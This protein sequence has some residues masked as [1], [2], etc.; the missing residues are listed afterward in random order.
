MMKAFI[1]FSLLSCFM[2]LA[3]NSEAQTE[4]SPLDTIKVS[5]E[6]KNGSLLDLFKQI[7]AQTQ[8]TFAYREDII[9]SPIGINIAKDTLTVKDALDI[10]LARTTLTYRLQDYSIVISKKNESPVNP[11]IISGSVKDKTGAPIPG[12]SIMIR[13]SSQGT[14]T[15]ENGNFN[16][17]VLSNEYIVFSFVG[18]KTFTTSPG[19]LTVIDVILEEDVSLLR[20]VVVSAGYYDVKKTESTGNISRVTAKDLEKQPVNNPLAALQGRMPGVFIQQT[21][22]TPGGEF[23]IQIR[24][25]NSLRVDGND[26]LY[27]IDGVILST[28]K[29]FSYYANSGGVF[30]GPGGASSGSGVSPLTLLNMADIESIEIL[31]DADATAIYGSRGANGVVLITTKKGKPGK[32]TFDLNVY[33]GV[34]TVKPIDYLNT[35]E[36]LALRRQAFANDGLIP[37]AN[38][39]DDGSAAN[40]FRLFAPDLMVWDTTRYTNW[41]KK[42]IKQAATTSVQASLSGGSELTKFLFSVGYRRENS[43]YPG[44]LA[45]QK[46]SFH[47][48]T[49][50]S[51][52][53]KKLNVDVSITG[54][55][56]RNDQPGLALMEQINLPPN[57]PELLNDDG[58]LNWNDWEYSSTG[59]NPLYGS[60]ITYYSNAVNFNGNTAIGYEILEGLRLKSS[61]GI[62]YLHSDERNIKPSTYYNPNLN[63]TSEQ[64][65]VTDAFGTN[66]SWLIEPQLTWDKQAGKAKVNI[67]IGTTFQE[68]QLARQADLYIGFPSDALANNLAAATTKYNWEYVRTLYRYS[69]LFGRVNF[70]W[71]GK[72]ILNLTARRDGSSRFGPRKQFANF[73]AIG[74]AWLFSNESFI[75]DNISFLSFGKLRGSY[76]STGNDQIGDYQYLDSYVP[77]SLGA[78]QY[79]GVAILSPAQLFNADYAWETNKKFEA[80]IELGFI[81]DR[82]NLSVS[83][84]LNRSSNQLVNYTLPQTTGFGGILANLPAVVQNTGIEIELSTV[85]IKTEH[86]NWSTSVNVTVPR[87]KLISF[88]DL[89]SS[90]YANQYVVGKPLSITSVFTSTG[91]DPQSGLWTFKDADGDGFVT[92]ENDRTKFVYTGYDYFGGFSNTFSY[93]GLTLDV[94]FQFVKQTGT[95]A[96][97]GYPGG[98]FNVPTSA[99][100][101]D[102]WTEEGD[103][104]TRQ[105]FFVNDPDAQDAFGKYRNSDAARKDASFIRLKN[106][107]VSYTVP[108]KWTKAVGCRVYV[109]G[110]NLLLITKYKGGDPETQYYGVLPPLRMLTAG[111][112]FT[113]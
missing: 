14:V 27:V 112:Q 49:T 61:F 105:R 11:V 103:Q 29:T 69:A 80:A 38:P 67:L 101:G 87:N 77:G 83:Y 50:H 17:A 108:K 84:F 40:G 23:R 66:Q 98:F 111:V 72:Y 30:S 89:E 42:F 81:E 15:D 36:Y 63:Y 56:D 53:N 1:W 106:L 99:I 47:F 10:A 110:Q 20:E 82:I 60:E 88:P 95:S 3:F 6:L 24:G 59:L 26:P 52:A 43:V 96:E 25:R 2:L 21:S 34:G 74:F 28:E 73:G 45:Y 102:I 13:E 57:A 65:S 93:K 22:G 79:Q 107:S 44:D 35:K 33:S 48:S 46:G 109:Q 113:L 12:V 97:A 37:S 91:V 75:K 9:N 5:I 86:F 64:T 8:F 54:T 78:N 62:S 32:T 16:L 90:T 51:S 100:E 18:Y 55:K 85:N 7:E 19:G 68:Q 39:N 92:F 31:K 76:G 71:D 94:L 104:A 70:N 58:S 4:L 41:Q